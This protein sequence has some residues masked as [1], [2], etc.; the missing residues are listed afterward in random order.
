MTN[1]V[2]P[3]L[4]LAFLNDAWNR[5]GAGA[6]TLRETLL[7]DQSAALAFVK[8]G[9][10]AS[11]SKNSASQAYRGYGAGSLTQVQIVEV[12]G[13]LLG[14][15]DQLQSK[16]TCEFTAS[17]DFDY[18]VPAGFDFDAPVYTLLTQVFNAQ[19]SGVAQLLPDISRLRL[20][21]NTILNPEVTTW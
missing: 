3:Q 21:P 2:S 18:I 4:C 1:D 9:S 16:I 11:V 10:I 6:N 20:P 15:Y 13:N 5:A 12:I 7:A 19:S 17:A 14:L 8:G